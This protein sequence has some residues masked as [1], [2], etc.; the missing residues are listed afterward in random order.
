[1]KIYLYCCCIISLLNC[2]FGKKKDNALAKENEL[3]N[4][5]FEGFVQ[6]LDSWPHLK[7]TVNI[8]T[9][10]RHD[11]VSVAF[12]CTYGESELSEA[13]AL[14]RF[15]GVTFYCVGNYLPNPLFDIPY[16]KS[17]TLV[18]QNNDTSK[19]DSIIP[20]RNE[21][22]SWQFCFFRDKIV[23][24]FPHDSLL[25]FKVDSISKW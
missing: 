3:G 21:T 17:D 19:F 24:Y 18:F 14:I 13:Y 5:I 9:Q 2:N 25:N 1:M 4:A 7:K 23:W 16:H 12:L 11:S 10:N 8:Y 20:P 6:E 15:K 22:P